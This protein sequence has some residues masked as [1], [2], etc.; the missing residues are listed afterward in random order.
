MPTE[1]TTN[2]ETKHIGQ[3]LQLRRA[4]QRRDQAALADRAVPLTAAAEILGCT[5]NALYRLVERRRV[6][7]R[8]SGK[9]LLFLVNELAAYLNDLPGL[10]LDQI[11]ER[12]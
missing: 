8:K 6:P 4:G 10:T 9:K 11:R 1:L 2:H 12:E 5:P 3:D 7:F